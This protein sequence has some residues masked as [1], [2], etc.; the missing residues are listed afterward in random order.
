MKLSG[1]TA[2]VTGASSGIGRA[3][4]HLFAREGAQI[5]AAARTAAA[6]E[7]LKSEIGAIGG[8]IICMS[9]DVQSESYN[10]ALVSMAIEHFGSL[11]IAV[12]NA[13]TLG[14]LGEITDLSAESWRQ[15]IDTN[16]TSA[17]FAA[18]YQIPAL[19]ASGGGSM[20]FTA[21]FVGYTVAMPAMSAYAA[22]KAGLIGF[23]QNLAVEYGRKGIR[24]NSLLPGGTETPM[25]QSFLTDAETRKKV[26]ELHGLGRLAAPEEIARAALFL[27]SDSASFVTGIPL[28]VDG[29]ISIYRGGFN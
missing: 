24:V 16:L 29:G 26:E 7:N 13:G 8:N 25:G 10:S 12:N 9:G 17:F 18:K 19:L 5:V 2:I 4:T 22:S 1:K 21:S 6:L 3:I 14:D 23:A 15:T 28:R 20:I 11:D 27:A